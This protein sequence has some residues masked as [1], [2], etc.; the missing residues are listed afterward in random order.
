MVVVIGEVVVVV[1]VAGLKW[2][3]KVG[4]EDPLNVAVNKPLILYS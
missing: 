1:M 2:F 3:F 4:V